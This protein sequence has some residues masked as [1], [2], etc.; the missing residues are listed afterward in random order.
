MNRRDFLKLMGVASSASLVS[1]C[2]LDK[3]TEKLISRLVPPEDDIAPGQ[4]VYYNT[5]CT[6]CPANCGLSVK[7]REGSPIKLEGISEHPINDGSLCIRGQSSL[8]RL[9][10]PER[11]KNPLIRNSQGNFKD[12]TW[13]EAYYI[14]DFVFWVGIAHSGTLISAVLFLFRARFRS[15]FNRAA[16]AMTVFV[17][18]TAGLFP[19]IHLGRVWLFYWLLPY[20]NQRLRV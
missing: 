15:S 14:T 10:H 7:V 2:G 17:V 3:R 12:T 13:N 9:Y 1:S 4:S 5:T 11:I 20:P 8:T 18:M 6:E 19:L 16:E